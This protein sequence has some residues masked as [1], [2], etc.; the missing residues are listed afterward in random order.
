M[1]ELIVVLSFMLGKRVDASIAL[2]LLLVNAVLGFLQEQRASAA[3]FAAAEHYLQSVLAAAGSGLSSPNFCMR[4][5]RALRVMS[6]Y[7]AA[8]V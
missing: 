5:K 2:G 8:L 4:Y 3:V 6:R 7:A 1:L